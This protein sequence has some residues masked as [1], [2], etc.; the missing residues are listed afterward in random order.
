MGDSIRDA[1]FSFDSE[2]SLRWAITLLH[3]LWQG[4][5]VG[6]VAAIASWLLKQHA[7]ALRYWLSAVALLACPVC[8]AVTFSLVTVPDNLLGRSTAESEL[9]VAGR[10][11][12]NAAFPLND[13][14]YPGVTLPTSDTMSS[15]AVD[16]STNSSTHAFRANAAS[17][18]IPTASAF[19]SQDES[20]KWYRVIAMWTTVAYGVGV[21]CFLLRL[22]VAL[23]G[24]QR[25][26]ANSILLSDSA[27]LTLVC[28]QAQRIG[29]RLVP[30][31]AY[32]ERVAVPTVIG[33][34]R[35]I[36]L[37]PASIVTGLTTD[38][39]SAIISHE[40]AHIRRYD[41]W[42][43]LLQRLIESVLFFHPVVWFL[44]RRLSAEREVCCD[45]LVVRSGHEAMNYAG[46][47]LRMAEL[48]AIPRY[49][50]AAALTAT[51]RSMSLLEHRI[52]RLIN[53]QQEPRL[54]L[55][56]I[57]VVTLILTLVC[58]FATPGV[59]RSF[60]RAQQPQVTEDASDFS[61]ATP[62]AQKNSETRE[63]TTATP[64]AATRAEDAMVTI[65]GRILLEDG[66]P[67]TAVGQMSYEARQNNNTNSGSVGQFSDCFSMTLPAGTISISHFADGFAP[68]WTEQFETK[69]GE[70]RDDLTIVLKLGTAKRIRVSNEDGKPISGATVLALPVRHGSHNGPVD[71]KTTDEKGELL[72]E[73]LAESPY[74][75][76]IEA[77]GYQ[78]LRANSVDVSSDGV[79]EQILIRSEIASGVIYNA[80]GS[81]AAG[82]KLLA[83]VEVFEN[84]DSNNIGDPSDAFW[85][86]SFATTN[87]EGRFKLDQ[88]SSTSHYL[89]IIQTADGARAVI[90]DIRAGQRDL[91]IT[92]PKRLDLKVT[93][94]G[95]ASEI[96]QRQGKPFLSVRQR[97]DLRSGDR[98]LYGALMGGDA[99]IEVSETGGTAVF[100]GLAVD[101]N[102]DAPAQ[103]VEI[104]LGYDKD[105]SQTVPMNLNGETEV[106]FELS[107]KVQDSVTQGLLNETSKQSE[108]RFPHC[109]LDIENVPDR[110]LLDSINGFNLEAK[111]SPIG[112]SQP[113]V[114]EEETRDAIAKFADQSH[115]P[116][117]VKEQLREIQKTGTLPS[118]VYFR[119]FTR[120]DDE[121]QMHGVWWVR[122]VVQPLEG[123]VF[124][125]PVR[126]T[127]IYSRPYTQME[128]QR[129]AADGLTLI[130]RVSSYYEAPPVLREALPLNQA[131]VDRLIER[132]QSA[133]K[134]KDLAAM[135]T[136]FEWKDA[137]DSIRKFAE[138]EFTTRTEATIHSIKVTT[139]TLDGNLITWSA[140]QKYKPN[141]PVVG[142]LEIEYSENR[143]A[144]G[145]EP[146]GTTE[147]PD[148]SRRADALPLAEM[149]RKTLSLELGQVGN[150]LRLVNYVTDGEPDPPKSLNPGPSITGHIELLA[151]GTFLVTDIITNPGTLLSAHLANEE[152]RQR[153]FNRKKVAAEAEPD[154]LDDSAGDKA[155]PKTK[156]D[157]PAASIAKPL[158]ESQQRELLLKAVAEADQIPDEQA[159]QKAQW[160]LVGM[161]V[162]RGLTEEAFQQA[163]KLK[164]VNPQ[165]CIYSL[166]TIAQDAMTKGNEADVQRAWELAKAA[167]SDA[168]QAFGFEHYVIQMGFK[169][170]R[171][172]DDLIAVASAAKPNGRQ[173][174]FRDIRN[175]LAW[176]GR[177]DEAYSITAKYLPTFSKE[178]NDRE[179]AYY[180]S[181]AKHYDYNVKHDHFGQAIRII[182]QMPRGTN[183]NA[184]LEQLIQGLLYVAGKDTVSEERF[185]LAEKWVDQI[186]DGLKQA[187]TRARIMKAHEDKVVLDLVNVTAEQAQIMNIRRPVQSLEVLEL[188]FSE[189]SSR[190]EK[191]VLLQRIFRKQLESGDFK[192]ADGMLAR[193]IQLIKEQPR[194][195]QKSKFG[196]FD[197]ADAVRLATWSHHHDIIQALIKADRKEEARARL[198]KLTDVPDSESLF[199]VGNGEGIRLMLYRELKDFDAVEKIGVKENNPLATIEMA[200]W[201]MQ[202]GQFDRGWKHVAPLL[203]VTSDALFPP[204]IRTKSLYFAA[205]PIESL[206][207]ELFKV[208]RPDDAFVFVNKLPESR[209]KAHVFE[210]F[211]ELL[212]TSGRI[213][214]LEQWI[215]KLP[216]ETARTH[217]RMGALR[218]IRADEADDK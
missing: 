6:I 58:F 139:R 195:E 34:L 208:N 113:P 156:A 28:N 21:V 32:C 129:N 116:D 43:N 188:A 10:E 211:G 180:C 164:P 121:Q 147:M 26:R 119:R 107:S 112:S 175:E 12:G 20:A 142:Y 94:K 186:D 150:E 202:N 140:W 81:P 69:P 181:N 161:L 65:S 3:F 198:D 56:R 187:K 124:S 117:K 49:Q 16:S 42:M 177:I 126:T 200:A 74:W 115:V 146:S 88:L 141:V 24:G 59:V 159:R 101:L 46:A 97:V 50:N 92:V 2:L 151:D 62:N 209:D 136:L 33:V 96:R 203:E 37:L 109:I 35:P 194:E 213:A 40:F 63:E 83:N 104:S 174:A 36:V 44:S 53:A 127:S 80:D 215:A 77:K 99:F 22:S 72:L 31:V 38:E 169:F 207:K 64:K 51:G 14:P 52:G 212:V 17:A 152:V 103:M 60:A 193:R 148:S 190:E 61:L 9:R 105:L 149:K 189:T 76:R 95:D 191:E 134:A 102:P 84:G 166:T 4:C 15:T 182:E 13:V 23:W 122:L 216:H 128:R 47:L 178:F 162:K 135:K 214:E 165:T 205:Q 218:S 167:N 89:F 71:K 91:K 179:I 125:V 173:N 86:A 185:S 192:A 48:C 145:R 67:A 138:S 131:A 204:D 1:L 54:Q 39:F 45:D 8:V 196:N 201:M 82:A 168:P 217:A 170:N 73:H 110:P 176:R 137:S 206:A 19:T 85:G 87:S 157:E 133:I 100:H 90:S 66:S 154:A 30:V 199:L 75:F 5:M 160:D 118:N 7:A 108:I 111:E 78:T 106:T 41:L 155:D 11:F 55:T 93:V 143:R 79:L 171:P 18:V 57:G 29:L 130:G 153:D 70:V 172:I 132:V 183:R 27:L 144:D 123:G 158:D 163:L 120:L 184:A 25:L 114:T 210:T 197:D 68:A 98:Q